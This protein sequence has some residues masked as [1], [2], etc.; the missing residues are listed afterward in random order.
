MKHLRKE[1][2]KTLNNADAY[3]DWFSVQKMDFAG[4]LLQHI[5]PGGFWGDG[6][7]Q[8][9]CN[10]PEFSDCRIYLTFDDGPSPATTPWLLELLE[11]ESVKASFFLIGREAEKYPDL[12][13]AI[14]KGGH[15]IGNHSYSH[16][17]MP[18]LKLAQIEKEIESTNRIITDSGA[19]TPT[20][21]RPPYGLMDRR[22]KEV[23]KEHSM[24]AVYWS[25][26]PE[27]WCSP[28]PARVV[29]RV[30][31]GLKVG[32][33]IVLHE[34]EG[35]KEQTFAAAKELIYKCK[36]AKLSLEKVELSA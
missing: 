21:F 32:G 36:S 25:Q 7:E 33:L 19:P 34:G 31:L 6:H 24:S 35:L 20:I 17:F 5:L 29:R 27:D 16:R 2:L 12:V 3:L 10:H 8:N 30:L 1:Q 9:H 15:S 28:G 22:A 26:A 4:K 23:L 18:A 13:E 14:Q 11:K